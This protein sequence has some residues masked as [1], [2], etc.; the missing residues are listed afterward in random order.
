MMQQFLIV[1][2]LIF[3]LLNPVT[4]NKYDLILGIFLL[5]FV[6]YNIFSKAA[7]RRQNFPILVIILVFLTTSV[8]TGGELRQM[9]TRD[10]PFFTYN[11]DP[12]VFL[13]T[14]K[15]IE[16]GQ[17]YYLSLLNAHDG[18]FSQR[19][20][21]TDIWGLRMPTLFYIWSFLP[22]EGLGIY[23]LFITLSSA[24]LYC[25]YKISEKYFERNIG[26]LS[27]YLLFPY[28]HYA[29]RDQM[30]LETEWWGVL[31][32][33]IGLYF[34]LFR[35]YFLATVLLSLSTL[36]R[37]L[38]I[39][40]VF[41]LLIY[42]FI[43]NRKLIYIAAIP[44]FAFGFLF[45]F[46]LTAAS[47]YIDAYGSL[48]KP[49][50]IP[51]GYTFLQQ[52][53]AYG[54]WEYFFYKFKPFYIFFILAIV[55]SIYVYLRKSRVDGLIILSSFLIFPIVFL[56]IGTLPFNDYWGIMFM[57]QVLIFAPLSLGWFLKSSK[58]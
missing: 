31:I 50:V 33:I 29:A 32:F 20:M 23:F 35:K 10:L 54:S 51:F 7:S 25:A 13:K 48:L 34:L 18:R 19:G 9:L 14:Y 56:K 47:Y 40:P 58:K 44:F 30:M 27:S 22:G 15:E 57:P 16:S 21:P 39:I 8:I 3:G 53:L 24:A 4:G 45:L 36:I 1:V 49:R 26:L 28:L 46:H 43:T 2:F 5:V 38:F 42:Y 37:E 12:G 52:T 55:G 17:P 6:G 41:L 11:N